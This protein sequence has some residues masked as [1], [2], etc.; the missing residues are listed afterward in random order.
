[1]TTQELIDALKRADPTGK[2]YVMIYVD[3]SSDVAF[4][5]SEPYMGEDESDNSRKWVVIPTGGFW[6]LG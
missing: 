3:S 1:M 6:E 5:P 4:H 2:L